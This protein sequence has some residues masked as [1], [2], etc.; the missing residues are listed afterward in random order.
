MVLYEGKEPGEQHY[1]MVGDQIKYE[2]AWALN[3][4]H[5]AT[6]SILNTAGNT[7]SLAGKCAFY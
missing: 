7:K 1:I 3:D 6:M 5:K 4:E 2:P